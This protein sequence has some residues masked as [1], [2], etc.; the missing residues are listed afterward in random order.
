M[1][2]KLFFLS[3]VFSLLVATSVATTKTDAAVCKAISGL[4]RRCTASDLFCG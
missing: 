2:T 3:L 1:N 4:Q